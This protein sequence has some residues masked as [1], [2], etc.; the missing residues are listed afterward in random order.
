M[1]ASSVLSVIASKYDSVANRNEFI[2]L[3]ELRVNRCWFGEK[4]DLAVAYMAAHLIT[5]DG[6]NSIRS[7]GE[8]GS[9]TSKREGDLA[10]SFSSTSVAGD[11]EDLNLTH[12]GV[13]YQSLASGSGLAIGVTGGNDIVC[14]S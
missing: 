5:L 12:Y 7:N 11:G 8:A 9:I 10:I 3:A 4:A 1:S 6:E 14:G 2:A 13:Q